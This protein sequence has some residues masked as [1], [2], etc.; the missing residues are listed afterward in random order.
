M[1][2]QT[3][4]DLAEKVLALSNSAAECLDFSDVRKVNRGSSAICQ[5]AALARDA[6]RYKEAITHVI[7]DSPGTPQSVKNY[8]LRILEAR[9]RA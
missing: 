9:T 3:V 5:L 2:M 4:G 7:D 1:G 6:E 8:L